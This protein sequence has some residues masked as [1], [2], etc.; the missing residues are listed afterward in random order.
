M[1]APPRHNQIPADRLSAKHDE[2]EYFSLA[3]DPDAIDIVETESNG[4]FADMPAER[5]ESEPDNE[6]FY[7]NL[8]KG[9]SDVQKNRIATEQIR[10]IEMDKEARAKR[11]QQ[12]EEGIKRTGMGK[13]APGG[14]DFEGASKVVHP[15]MTE[16]CIDYQSRIMKELMPPQ[17]PVK[18]GLIGAVT[19]QK[20]DKAIRVS[21]FLNYQIMH[22]IKGARAT[23]EVLFAQVPLGGSQ[24]IRQY[25][26]H[27]LKQPAWQFASI[28]HV[29]VPFNAADFASAKRKTFIDTVDQVEFRR[30]VAQGMYLDVSLP[31]PT[32]FK[33]DETRSD[34]ASAKVEGKEDPG[35]NL[36]DDRILY[37]VMCYLEITEDFLA[38]IGDDGGE[39]VG[40]MCPY[41]VTIDQS[42]K[43]MLAMYRSWEDGDSA[44]DPIEH[45]FEFGFIPWRGAYSIG[46]PQIIGGLSAAATGALRG[47]LDSAHV[48]NIPSGLVLKGSGI[49]GQSRMPNPGELVEVDSSMESDDIRKRVMPMPFNQPSNVLFALLGFLVDGAKGVVR[50]SMDEGPQNTAPNTPVGTQISRVEEGLVVFS[51]IHGRAHDGMDRLIR[52]LRRL[53]RLYLPDEIKVDRLGREILVSR[54]DFEG[55]CDISPASNPTIYSEMQRFNQLAYIQQRQMVVPQLYKARE[56][57]LAGLKLIKWPDPETLLV[58]VPEPTEQNAVNENLA[59]VLAQPIAVY[60]DQNHMAHLQV[61]LDFIGSPALGM[62]PL[63]GPTVLAPLVKHCSEHLAYFYAQRIGQVVTEAAG[64]PHHTLSGDEPEVKVAFDKL[65]AMAS[66]KVTPEI[67]KAIQE[68]MPVL[69]AAMQH[70][71]QMSPPQPMDPSQAAVQAAQAETGRKTAADQAKHQLEGAKLQTDTTLATQKQQSDATAEA[72]RV[73]NDRV[74]NAVEMER[75]RV[76]GENAQVAA[77]TK[78]ETTQIDAETALEISQ[79][80]LAQGAKGNFKNGSSLTK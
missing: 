71:Q 80:R 77:H 72:D 3:D 17:G 74:R 56:V 57:E 68:A 24:Y 66:Q 58:S 51:A 76:M 44:Y 60:P 32:S 53:N 33:M 21:E 38:A 34:A 13:D 36:D 18:P 27:A 37:E 22:Q 55:P 50:T 46:F 47:L 9:L 54:D 1:A 19:K 73:Q 10:L 52:G 63:Y 6:G 7:S 39:E 43:E 70:I 4:A 45:L 25:W 12:Y 67:T 61:H 20:T 41:L 79:D 2:A 42:S 48:N 40:Q 62:S 49:G 26:D 14:A 11:D 64:V 29:L 16:A 75:V 35:E 69:A 59:A 31:K 23:L 65:L 28:D 15:M 78:I 30:R 8:A 5:A